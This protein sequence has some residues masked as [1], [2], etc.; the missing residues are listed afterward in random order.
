[1]KEKKGEETHA[2]V[3]VSAP[4]TYFWGPE[5]LIILLDESQFVAINH[6]DH[7]ICREMFATGLGL[8]GM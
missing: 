5:S 6:E 3:R 1:M 8:E 4:Q 2:C 7:H